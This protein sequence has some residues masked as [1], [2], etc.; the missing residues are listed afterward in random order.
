MKPAI[1]ALLALGALCG[2]C[3]PYPGYGYPAPRPMASEQECTAIRQ[4]IARQQRIAEDS[5]VMT[6]PLVQW[7]ILLNTT[8]VITGLQ[9]QAAIAGCPA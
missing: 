2:G 5:G 3:A 4:E 8:N 6:S 1:A 7:S 9:Q